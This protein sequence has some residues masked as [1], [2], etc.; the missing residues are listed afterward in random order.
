MS[1]WFW[2]IL[3]AIAIP[4]IVFVGWWLLIASEGVYLGRRVVIWLYDL[5][6]PRYDGIKGFRQEYDHRFL[7]QPMMKRL[8]PETAPLILDVATG[9]GRFPLAMSRHPKFRGR[10]IGVDLSRPML[11]YGQ[12][13]FGVI[14]NR[15]ARVNLMQANAERLPFPD[16]CFDAVTCLEALEFMIHQ[17]VVL[18]EM[19]RVL[20]PG[21]V[22]LITNRI[23]TRWMPRKTYTTE[24]Y[25]DLLFS[26]GVDDISVEKWQVDYDRVWGIKQSEPNA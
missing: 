18:A 3:L 22:L 26:V 9:T 21:G 19:L 6:A 5:F 10:V 15:Y 20:K 1:D 24:Q 2:L 13:K 23:N 17:Q 14:Q 8:A 4:L 7:A 25:V 11:R 12:P 16:A